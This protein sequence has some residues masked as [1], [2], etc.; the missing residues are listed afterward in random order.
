MKFYIKKIFRA[1][2]KYFPKKYVYIYLRLKSSRDTSIGQDFK[3]RVGFFFLGEN[4]NI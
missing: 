3:K 1:N 4:N 2:K